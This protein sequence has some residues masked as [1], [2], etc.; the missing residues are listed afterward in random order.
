VTL[1]NRVSVAAALGVLIVVGSVSGILYV[2]YAANVRA[3]VDSDLVNAAQQ[4]SAV[5]RQIKEAQANNISG[6]DG[7][8]MPENGAGLSR[9]VSVGSIQLQAFPPP[10]VAGQSTRFGPFTTRDA[11]IAEGVGDPYFSNATDGGTQYRVYTATMLGSDALVRT[12]RA[13]NADDGALRN[14]ALLLAALTLAATAVT[15]GIARLTAARVLRPIGQLTAA[16]EH[17]T[18]TRDLTAR[19]G[20]TATDEVGRL[21]ASFDTML[22][23]LHD[24]V[25]AQRQLVA[26]ASH[27]LR[28]PLTSLTTNLDLLEDGAG[29][30]DAQA[31]ALVAAAREQ[32]AELDR[33]VSDLLDLARYREAVPHR[34]IV[35]LDLLTHDAV[36][37]LQ[38]RTAPIRIETDL[39]PSLVEVDPAAVHRAVTNLIENAIKWSP[40]GG[41]VRILVEDGRIS[42]TDQGPGIPDEDLAHIFERFYRAPAARGMPG[43]GLGLAIVGSVAEANE[44]H[45]DIRT[46]PDG[47]TFTLVFAS[48]GADDVAG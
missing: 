10:V 31:P 46:G 47:S 35:S 28:T 7:R 21:S 41:T 2:S 24:A 5:A 33:L 27:E 38:S 15:Y 19:L 45:V 16:A 23:S 12:S 43:A 39:R 29:L 30:A 44:G 22:A 48:V 1:R 36:H 18:A 20:S 26:D 32:A 11:S 13:L 3:R 37:R 25:I 34:E 8:N 40:A 17:V 14:V 6:P 4:A 42:V 9:P